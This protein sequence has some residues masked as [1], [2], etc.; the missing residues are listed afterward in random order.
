[1]IFSQ[2]W[3]F[4]NSLL[5]KLHAREFLS[6]DETA[7][8]ATVFNVLNRVGD[9]AEKAKIFKKQ[10]ELT[11]KRRQDKRRKIVQN[12]LQKYETIHLPRLVLHALALTDA[13]RLDRFY[14]LKLSSLS[15]L[16]SKTR[17]HG[18]SAPYSYV[19]RELKERYASTINRIA[20]N[21]SC[22]KDP[23]D[24]LL[25]SLVDEVDEAIPR[26]EKHQRDILEAFGVWLVEQ[27]LMETNNTR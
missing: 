10:E 13:A 17:K 3:A 21:F 26:I 8:F 25:A 16:Q 19:S 2:I 4:F 22:K 12:V 23:L 24:G 14:G 6:E 27:Q 15:E 18:R 9:A 5:R 1:M 20:Y 7:A 11:E